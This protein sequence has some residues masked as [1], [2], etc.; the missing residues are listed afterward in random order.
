MRGI[1]A[2]MTVKEAAEYL[3]EPGKKKDL[4]RWAETFGI[5]LHEFHIGHIKTYQADRGQES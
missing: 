3:A 4:Q 1:V 2:T 5:P